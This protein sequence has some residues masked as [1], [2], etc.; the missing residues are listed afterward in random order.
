MSPRE[1]LE[2]GAVSNRTMPHSTVIPQLVYEDVGEAIVWL[3]D[4][5]G[6]VDARPRLAA[7]EA[8][9]RRSATPRARG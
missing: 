3:C 8:S 4:R 2:P 6:L 5:F 1:E 9:Q 7:G